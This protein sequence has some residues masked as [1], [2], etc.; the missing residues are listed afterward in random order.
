VKI[1]LR[2]PGAWEVAVVF[3]SNNWQHLEKEKDDLFVGK[4][5]VPFYTSATVVARSSREEAGWA[6]LLEY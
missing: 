2:V 5:S 3:D 4:V 6:V 1:R